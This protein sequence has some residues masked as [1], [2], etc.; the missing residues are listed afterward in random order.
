M[1]IIRIVDVTS[2]NLD[3]YRLELID[4]AYADQSIGLYL[5]AVR[6]L[7]Q[8]LEETRQIFINPAASMIIP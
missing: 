4:K 2:I 6:K 7:F 3:T 1:N 5:R 8:Y